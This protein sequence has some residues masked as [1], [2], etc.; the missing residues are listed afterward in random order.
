MTHFMDTEELNFSKLPDWKWMSIYEW[1]ETM[2]SLKKRNPY[3]KNL[4]NR[5]QNFLSIPRLI[6][7]LESLAENAHKSANYYQSERY[8]E[9]LLYIYDNVDKF[10]L[11]KNHFTKAGRQAHSSDSSG[12]LKSGQNITE[13]IPRSR[14]LKNL[15]LNQK[16]VRINNEIIKVTIKNQNFEKGLSYIANNVFLYYNSVKM[17]N[18]TDPQKYPKKGNDKIILQASNTYESDMVVNA[19]F[20]QILAFF[21]RGFKDTIAL[22][23]EI[24]V[25]VNNNF[26]IVDGDLYEAVKNC[27]ETLEKIQKFSKKNLWSYINKYVKTPDYT[28]PELRP[29]F[30]MD[31]YFP[32]YTGVIEHHEYE[33]WVLEKLKFLPEGQTSPN[34][35]LQNKHNYEQEIA[36]SKNKGDRVLKVNDV[37]MYYALNSHPNELV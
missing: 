5:L 34:I 36:S 13:S 15:Q 27:L 7:I 11:I 35:Q 29:E 8:Y 24:W 18:D 28:K 19:Q 26:N 2:N 33:R 1:V 12:Y 9:H 10:E 23:K 22:H 14:A 25:A 16:F 37:I 6:D 3:M 30:L 17:I 32:G 31:I 21:N 4:L 20:Q